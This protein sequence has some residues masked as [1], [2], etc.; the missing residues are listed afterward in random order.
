MFFKK[1]MVHRID[2]TSLGRI[3]FT[4]HWIGWKLGISSAPL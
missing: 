1:K 2:R 3:A 4:R